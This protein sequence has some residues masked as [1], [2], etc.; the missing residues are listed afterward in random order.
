MNETIVRCFLAQLREQPPFRSLAPETDDVPAAVDALRFLR[1]QNVI[2]RDIKPQVRLLC[3]TRGVVEASP[4]C[5]LHRTFCSNPRTLPTSRPGILPGFRSLKSPTLD[6]LGGCPR[7]AWL[8]LFADLRA[9]SLLPSWTV[10]PRTDEIPSPLRL[11]MAPE[12]LR[13][14]KYDAKADLWSVGAVLFEMSVGKPP[15]RAQNHVD[16]LRKIEKGEDKIRFPDDKKLEEGTDKVPTQVAPD[17]KALIRR[18]LKRNPT[19]RMNFDDFFREAHAVAIGG[20]AANLSTPEHRR[21]ASNAGPGPPPVRTASPDVRGAFVVTA[22]AAAY[23]QPP[24][25]PTVSPTPPPPRIPAY[26]DQE[27][28]PFAR[29]VSVT[30]PASGGGSSRRSPTT[31]AP[32]YVVGGP[33]REE[34]PPRD[35]IKVRDF[36][37]QRGCVVSESPIVFVQMN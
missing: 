30:T 32:R 35:D 15:F 6:S 7:R 19:E 10:W 28:P 17:L 13:Y 29:R 5:S 20:T 25:M 3:V 16:L 34:E 12:I 4:D 37:I 23:A 24:V 26:I 36:A 2:H 9:L 14:E 21:S 31:F 1:S 33:S 11:Y 27:P 8:R 18:L 22:S